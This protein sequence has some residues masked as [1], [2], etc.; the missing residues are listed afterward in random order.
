MSKLFVINGVDFT[1]SIAMS[2][3]RVNRKDIG[4]S[5]VDGNKTEHMYIIRQQIDGTFSFKANSVEAYHSFCNEVNA[6]K[7]LTGKYAGS[8][9]VSLYLNNENRFVDAYVRL[10]FDPAD[11]LPYI[12]SGKTIEGFEVSIK[13]V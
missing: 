7:V 3:Y 8:V 11:E 6:N 13:E 10:T 12:N 1:Q 9:L 5:W 4:E 2:S